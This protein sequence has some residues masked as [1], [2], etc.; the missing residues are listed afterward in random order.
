MYPKET[1]KS[2]Q[3]M[4]QSG[5]VMKEIAD[6]FGFTEQGM[7]SFCYGLY[8][9]G[10]ITEEQQAKRRRILKKK[11]WEDRNRERNEKI[12]KMFEEEGKSAR[13]IA[14]EVSLTEF[15]VRSVINA[16]G[17]AKKKTPYPKNLVHAIM[18]NQ[19]LENIEYYW[20]VIE[21]IIIKLKER[22]Q[23]VIKEK[24]DN[25]KT[26]A[27]IGESLGVS[28]QRAKSICAY[29]F[30]K[31]RSTKEVQEIIKIGIYENRK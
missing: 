11:E 17:F 25:D 8:L 16:K 18:Q 9:I 4:Y 19:E 28:R 23:F 20:G 30:Q 21:P 2:I 26:Y 5:I 12:R 3:K 31:I 14:E 1:L 10:I 24:Y 15:G 13:V 7:R 22:E 29:S 27:Q 6:E